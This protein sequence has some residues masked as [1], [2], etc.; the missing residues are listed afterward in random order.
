MKDEFETTTEVAV[1]SF[2][3]SLS[4]WHA[5][6]VWKAST[7]ARGQKHEGEAPNSHE[8]LQKGAFHMCKTSESKHVMCQGILKV[9]IKVTNPA[10]TV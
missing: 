1:T 9:I 8:L 6:R 7:D 10:F 4:K 3:L 2:H 5:R